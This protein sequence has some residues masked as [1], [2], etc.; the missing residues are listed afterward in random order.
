[1]KEK[2]FPDYL[3]KYS[4]STYDIQIRDLTPYFFFSS[5]S[6]KKSNAYSKV[7]VVSYT[8]SFNYMA[9]SLVISILYVYLPFF[10]P[11]SDDCFPSLCTLRSPGH[12]WN[13]ILLTSLWYKSRSPKLMVFLFIFF[14]LFL[15]F[16]LTQRKLIHL[17]SVFMSFLWAYV[18]I[19]FSEG[20]VFFVVYGRIW[21]I[22]WW[23]IFL[24]LFLFYSFSLTFF[25]SLTFLP[26]VSLLCAFPHSQL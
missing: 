13:I 17:I 26:P 8:S 20:N 25:L 10:P 18:L 22:L 12:Y 11:F 19:F 23:W 3:R 24:P 15:I 5:V 14:F 2:E 9:D 21:S 4:L 1:M 16:Y 7:S 6:L